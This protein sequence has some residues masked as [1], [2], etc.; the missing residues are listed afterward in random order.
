MRPSPSFL[1]S[2]LLASLAAVVAVAMTATRSGADGTTS[3]PTEPTLTLA[4]D[5]WVREGTG[6]A[7][8]LTFRATVAPLSPGAVSFRVRTVGGSAKAGED[9]EP[10][11]RRVTIPA[12]ESSAAIVLRTVADSAEEPARE[13]LEIAVDEVE[14]ALDGA[15]PVAV[16]IADD[17]QPAEPGD[18]RAFGCVGGRDASDR[19]EVETAGFDGRAFATALAG[20]HDLYV[21]DGASIAHLRRDPGSEQLTP[22]GCLRVVDAAVPAPD[23]ASLPESEGEAPF[24]AASITRLAAAPDGR[25]LHA[26]LSEETGA[27]R[28]GVAVATFAIDPAGGGLTLAGCVG[29]ALVGPACDG[30]SGI[31]AAPTDFATLSASP[32]G[33]H[34]YLLAADAIRLLRVGPDG[35]P[36]RFRCADSGVAVEDGA[37]DPLLDRTDQLA[38]AVVSPDGARVAVTEEDRLRLYDRDADDGTLNEARERVVATDVAA[39]AWAPDGETLHLFSRRGDGAVETYDAATL[40]RTSCIESTGPAPGPGIGC[41][42]RSPLDLSG[43]TALTVAPGGERLRLLVPGGGIVTLTRAADGSLGGG[44]CHAPATDAGRCGDGSGDPLHQRLI[45]DLLTAPGGGALYALT[46]RALHR[47]VPVAPGGPNRA[48]TCSDAHVNGKPDR[49]LRIP[50]T[51]VDPDGDPLTLRVIAQP[52]R[53]TLGEP[54]GDGVVYRPAAGFRG[55]DGLRF[56]ADDGRGGIADAA[57]SIAVGNNA[58]VCSA[59][60]L[61]LQPGQRGHVELTCHDPDGD[62]VRTEVVRGPAR[63][64]LAYP[65][66]DAPAG[67]HGATDVLLRSADEWDAVETTVPIAVRL[68]PPDCSPATTAPLA[69]ASTRAV[70]RV[71][72]CHS[73]GLPAR[74]AIA[75]QSARLGR[76]KIQNGALLYTPLSVPLD[77]RDEIALRLTGADGQQATATVRAVVRQRADGT[78]RRGR[79]GDC[80]APCTPSR[81]GELEFRFVCDGRS[82]ASAGTCRGVLLVFQCQHGRCIQ[83]VGTAASAGAG[84]RTAVVRAG[85]SARTRSG[86]R[87]RARRAPRRM[88]LGRANVRAKAGRAIAVKVRLTP[89]ARRLVARTGKVRALV[90]FRL[91][92]PGGATRTVTRQITIRAPRR[93]ARR[94]GGRRGS[95]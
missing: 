93:A 50:L 43:A 40:E 17:D 64:G 77:D 13:T 62:R 55:G 53:G 83:A 54:D 61:E 27:G 20:E 67:W 2:C 84:V 76:A 23:C 24:G 81:R 78:A 66:Y 56:R 31:D 88:T 46:D 6:A 10:I 22:Q 70:R 52:A 26:A 74:V 15:E 21:T 7:R 95:R 59:K 30:G 72:D 29:D 44:R 8:T 28:V 36:G 5:D 94:P 73:A 38:R 85:A 19:C 80:R 71:L 18:L 75:R 92:R 11:D 58:P 32:D 49:E 91:Q 37:C 33:R 60:R 79:S 14:G 42:A 89:A 25:H 47:F 35:R 86:A 16:T 69:V 51:C 63:G 65:A 39:A 48:P 45:A 3:V 57:V 68:P 41:E 9:F 34:L 90:V 4:G 87:G 82:V 1:L 12:G